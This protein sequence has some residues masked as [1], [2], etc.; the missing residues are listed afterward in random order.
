MLISYIAKI[1]FVFTW[2]DLSNR[3]CL[4]IKYEMIKVNGTRNTTK[5][6]QMFHFRY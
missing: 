1:K 6:K 5:L 2:V 4:Y 3:A